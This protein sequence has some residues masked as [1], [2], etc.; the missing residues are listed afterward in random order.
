MNTQRLLY[1]RTEPFKTT[2]R[3]RSV[4]VGARSTPRDNGAF[5]LCRGRSAPHDRRPSRGVLELPFWTRNVCLPALGT[6]Q[7]RLEAALSTLPSFTGA[8][9]VFGDRAYLVLGKTRDCLRLIV[10]PGIPLTSDPTCARAMTTSKNSVRDFFPR[11]VHKMV[12][13]ISVSSLS[14]LPL[15]VATNKDSASSFSA[16]ASFNTA[17]ITGDHS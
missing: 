11:L 14:L 12:H 10:L 6:Q 9:C 8:G 16:G 1:F 2:G 15:T 17:A 7:T 13:W 4:V 3:S 5:A